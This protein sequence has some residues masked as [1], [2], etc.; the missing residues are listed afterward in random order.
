MSSIQELVVLVVEDEWFVS[1]TV[2]DELE[3]K[4]CHVL[5]AASGE[6]ALAYLSRGHAVDVVFTDIRLGGRIDG[7]DVAEAFREQDPYI[8]VI[9]TSGQTLDERHD[10]SGSLFYRKPHQ[11]DEV[12][13]ACC[14][15]AEARASD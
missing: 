3:S 1:M 4:G 14:W 6:D 13:D 9:Y 2:V 11:P 7:W 5:E 15:M 12:A 8:G 10:V